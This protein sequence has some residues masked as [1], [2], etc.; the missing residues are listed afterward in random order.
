ML[1]CEECECEDLVHLK[2]Y[3]LRIIILILVV[4]FSNLKA[5]GFSFDKVVTLNVQA[6]YHLGSRLVDMGRW[7]LTIE[8]NH[9]DIAAYPA[10][11]YNVGYEFGKN[12][13]TLYTE[14]QAGIGLAGYSTGFYFNFNQIE[15]GWQNSF[16]GNYILGIMYRNR[17]TFGDS[18]NH[19]ISPYTTVPIWLD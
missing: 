13:R 18:F 5:D 17:Y 9:W 15:F 12:T 14:F 19:I 2:G 16:W 3:M 10:L 8:V 6:N 4:G 1:P 7:T 11:G